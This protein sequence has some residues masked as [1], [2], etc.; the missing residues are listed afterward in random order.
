MQS[1]EKRAIAIFA[2]NEAKNIISCL[3]SVK[4]SM[5]ACDE[6]YVLN[7]GSCDDT[8]ELVR[9]FAKKNSFCKLISIEIGDKSNA[10]NVFCHELSISA[11]MY[12]FLDGDCTVV[13]GALDSLE[14]GLENNPSANACAAL[15]LESVSKKNREQMLREGGLAG[16]LYALSRNFLERIRSADVRLPVGFIGDDSLVGALA[17]WDLDPRNSWD[18]G[19]IVLCKDANFSYDP[20]SLLSVA[21]MR[22]YYRRKISYSLRRYQMSIIK[23]PLQMHGI[24]AI[25]KSV[26]DLYLNSPELLKLTWRGLD[27]WFDYLALKRIRKFMT[28][29]ARE[30][31]I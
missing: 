22:L 7:N 2:H 13:S 6:C 15:P 8:G 9:T 25:P 19:R 23:E 10:W 21:D 11:S 24:G 5:R 20:L 27:T 3:E 18:S 28:N 30:T 12:I 4:K 26:D 16:N 1:E 31:L 14:Y 29:R 17:C